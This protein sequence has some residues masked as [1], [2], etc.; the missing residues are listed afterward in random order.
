MI[1]RPLRKP[2]DLLLGPED[3]VPQGGDDD[4]GD[5]GLEELHPGLA[6]DVRRPVDEADPSPPNANHDG[7]RD[8]PGNDPQEECEQ[9]E[10]SPPGLL[11]IVPRKR[12]FR[13]C[14]QRHQGQQREDGRD[15]PDPGLGER[16]DHRVAFHLEVPQ[17]GDRVAQDLVSGKL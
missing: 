4:E 8:D 13:R 9:V 3:Q 15:D 16:E 17:V 7:R 6:A 11:A 1:T 10:R 5:Q 14:E 12:S 2:R